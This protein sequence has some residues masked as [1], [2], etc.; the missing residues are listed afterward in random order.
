MKYTL[1]F[2]FFGRCC[3]AALLLA[4]FSAGAHAAQPKEVAAPIPASNSTL[5]S[6]C[7]EKVKPTLKRVERIRDMGMSKGDIDTDIN[8]NISENGGGSRIVACQVQKD[9]SLRLI[10]KKSTAKPAG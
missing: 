5:Q 6:A 1:K 9:G 10:T 4:Q 7:V 8:F 2:S 3:G